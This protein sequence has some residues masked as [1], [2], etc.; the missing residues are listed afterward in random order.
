[1]PKY[2]EMIFFETSSRKVHS[3]Y[4]DTCFENL[5]RVCFEDA[6]NWENIEIDQANA[7]CAL[8]NGKVFPANRKIVKDPSNLSINVHEVEAILLVFQ[9]WAP[10]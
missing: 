6:M 1:M 5:G 10:K 2:N 9:T 8:V 4:T 3:F 7:F